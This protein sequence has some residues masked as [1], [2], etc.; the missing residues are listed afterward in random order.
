MRILNARRGVAFIA[1]LFRQKTMMRIR[2][3]D[4]LQKSYSLALG[5]GHARWQ[6][7]AGRG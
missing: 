6:N 5:C 3:N 1:V 2:T 4:T 7:G